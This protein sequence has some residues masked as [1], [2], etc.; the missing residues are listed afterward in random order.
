MWA[1]YFLTFIVILAAG[2]SWSTTSVS[3]FLPETI[4]DPKASILYLC[5]EHYISTTALKFS[6]DIFMYPNFSQVYE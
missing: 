3:F 6:F 2:G 4:F 5:A 1:D